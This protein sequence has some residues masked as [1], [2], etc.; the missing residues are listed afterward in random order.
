MDTAISIIPGIQL[1]P[2]TVP[3][4]YRPPT[5]VTS[6]NITAPTISPPLASSERV[7]QTNSRATSVTSE[8]DSQATPGISQEQQ[9]LLTDIVPHM[10]QYHPVR[11]R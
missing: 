6:V 11:H 7:S 2:P 4:P 3:T 8:R 1:G 9:K 5:P 10:L